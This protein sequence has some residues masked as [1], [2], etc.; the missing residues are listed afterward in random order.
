MKTRDRILDAA[1]LLFNAEGL[2]QVSTN[3][4]A[5][6]LDI[7]PGNL[8]YHFRR[9]EDLVAWLVR[10]FIEALRPYADVHQSIEAIDDLWVA[11]H[12]NLE[13]LDQYRFI[14]RD[15]DFLTREYPDL[16][17]PLRDLTGRRIASARAVLGKLREL[18]VISASDEQ[19]GALALQ[20]ILTNTAWYAFENLLPESDRLTVRGPR[21]AA[22]HLLLM[23]SP[24]VNEQSQR[25]LDYLGERYRPGALS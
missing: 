12:L 13:V 16:L 17:G 10:R 3:R 22:F 11:M 6:E 23:L 9:K 8:H 18:E 19:I 15:V 7:S 4:I 25:Y 14:L 21:A 24:L 1:R 5:A 20:T 2:A